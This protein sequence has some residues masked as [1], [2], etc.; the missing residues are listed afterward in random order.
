MARAAEDLHFSD[1]WSYEPIAC[2]GCRH[3]GQGT[4]LRL[5]FASSSSPK[6]EK[7]ASKMHFGAATGT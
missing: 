6:N 3:P 2:N 1:R 4:A 7:S 5:L